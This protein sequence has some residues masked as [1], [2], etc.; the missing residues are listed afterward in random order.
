MKR[1]LTEEKV[2]KKLDIEDFRHLTKDKVIEMSSMLDKMDPEVAMKALEQFPQ[3]ATTIKEMVS[4]YKNS[5]DKMVVE[6]KESTL[7]FY[8][9][10]TMTLDS[11]K[12][13]LDR[14]DLDFEQ[15]KYIVEKM[16]EVDHMIGSKDSEHKKFLAALAV[17]GVSALTIGAGIIAGALGVNTDSN[18]K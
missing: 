6:D 16:L 2:L 7:K 11:L 14:E 13:E 5:L 4:D 12:K 1:T 8:D 18:I 15:R 9:A 10:C 3:F 17:V